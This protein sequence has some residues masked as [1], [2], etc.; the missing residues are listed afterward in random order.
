M[1]GRLFVELALTVLVVGF[2]LLAAGIDIAL[3]LLA[4]VFAFFAVVAAVVLVA[5]VVAAAVVVI[6]R[7][8]LAVG[9]IELAQQ[10]LRE[11]G[12]RDLVVDREPQRVEIG[13]EE[14]KRGG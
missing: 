7:Q 12:E 13:A 8:H 9:E 3:A 6:V 14:R 4:G 2:L 1:F 10:L 5:F 11:I